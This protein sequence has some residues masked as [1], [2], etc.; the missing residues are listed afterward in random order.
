MIRKRYAGARWV[1][2]LRGGRDFLE[3]IEKTA[4]RHDRAAL[5]DKSGRC[6]FSMPYR[7]AGF[8]TGVVYCGKIRAGGYAA[9]PKKVTVAGQITTKSN[10]EIGVTVYAADDYT[11]PLDRIERIR[12]FIDSFKEAGLCD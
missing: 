3:A 7:T 1:G 8:F 5:F 4:V 2:D 11:E 6:F 12:P 9:G 10:G